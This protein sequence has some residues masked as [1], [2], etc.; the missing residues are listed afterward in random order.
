M[1]FNLIDICCIEETGRKYD[2]DTCEAGDDG[3]ELCKFYHR[4]ELECQ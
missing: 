3:C 1:P 2:K 4:L